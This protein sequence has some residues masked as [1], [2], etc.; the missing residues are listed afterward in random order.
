MKEGWFCAIVYC[1]YVIGAKVEFSIG[2]LIFWLF[3]PTIIAIGIILF[4]TLIGCLIAAYLK[5]KYSNDEYVEK[6]EKITNWIN[7][8]INDE[9]LNNIKDM[10]DL[11]KWVKKFGNINDVSIDTDDK[12]EKKNHKKHKKSSKSA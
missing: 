9:K 2:W 7:E 3:F 12:I 10:D 6:T 11:M 5:F 1:L 4:F 8:N